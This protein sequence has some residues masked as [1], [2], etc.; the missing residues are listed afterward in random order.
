MSNVVELQKYKPHMTG[1]VVCLNCKHEWVGVMPV[2][3]FNIEC[4]E[5]KSEKGVIKHF[6]IREGSIYQCNC[7]CDLLRARPDGCY[8]ANCGAWA[9]F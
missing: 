8:C 9:D 3:T 4:P 2:G 5:C 7:G 6:A 1:E